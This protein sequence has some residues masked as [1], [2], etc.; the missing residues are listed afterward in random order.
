MADHVGAR[1]RRWTNVVVLV[2]SAWALAASMWGWTPETMESG[3]RD[4]VTN[5]SLLV[6]AYALAGTL[7]FVAVFTAL[8][9]PALSK[10]LTALAGLLLLSGFLVLRSVDPVAVLSLGL[11]GIALLAAAPFMGPMPTPEEEGKHR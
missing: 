7:G 11:T 1:G 3:A 5:D 6:G 9:L 8:R 10:A 4:L 2:A